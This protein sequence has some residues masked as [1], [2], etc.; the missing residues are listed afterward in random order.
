MALSA[1]FPD[2]ENRTIPNFQFKELTIVVLS[3]QS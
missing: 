3:A 2:Y 1:L